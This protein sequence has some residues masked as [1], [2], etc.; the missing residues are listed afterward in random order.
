MEDCMSKGMK[1][2]LKVTFSIIVIIVIIFSRHANGIDEFKN[3]LN[4]INGSKLTSAIVKADTLFTQLN[5]RICMSVE[6]GV[7]MKSL[8]KKVVKGRS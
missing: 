4:P 2:A 6:L 8:N 5:R 3:K 1:N 7:S